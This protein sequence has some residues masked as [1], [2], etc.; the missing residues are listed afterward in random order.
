MRNF[1]KF[2]AEESKTRKVF[3]MLT[4][5]LYIFFPL[6]IFVFLAICSAFEIESSDYMVPAF[7]ALVFSLGAC[8]L[9]YKCAYKKPGTALLSLTI[10]SPVFYLASYF[11]Q[12][13]GI[14][15]F[16][17]D[18]NFI[19]FLFFCLW[20]VRYFYCFKMRSINRKVRAFIES[21]KRVRKYS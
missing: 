16:L 17:Q 14:S 3:L 21:K 10:W 12:N 9:D 15:E 7:V 19:S 2:N 8:L 18:F 11:L 4:Q 13:Q 5:T 1:Y 6:A 20:G